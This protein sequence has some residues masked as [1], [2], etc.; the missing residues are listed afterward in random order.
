MVH[1]FTASRALWRC[2]YCCKLL[3]VAPAVCT[4]VVTEFRNCGGC[5]ACCNVQCA[6]YDCHLLRSSFGT[7]TPSVPQLS[8]RSSH[9]SFIFI[10]FHS[11]FTTQQHQRQRQQ[12]W[13]ANAAREM[14]N[15]FLV[16]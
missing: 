12:Q 16:F 13:Q 5:L 1:N 8:R 4:T 11:L 3:I 7:S 2:Q 14:R 6:K 15:T 10:A 9:F